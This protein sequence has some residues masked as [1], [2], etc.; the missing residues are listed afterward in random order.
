MCFRHIMLS[1]EDKRH[2]E[3][4][5]LQLNAEYLAAHQTFSQQCTIMDVSSSGI[6]CILHQEVNEGTIIKLTC[7]LGSIVANLVATVV[8]ARP[9]N[10]NSVFSCAAGLRIMSE[11]TDD[12]ANLFQYALQQNINQA[13]D[14]L[15]SKIHHC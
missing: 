2:N 9:L 1:T 7:T 15:D 3:R 5:S 12:S 8:W 13:C 10:G 14:N 4:L 6:G 11:K